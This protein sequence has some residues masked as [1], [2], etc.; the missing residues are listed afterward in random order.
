MSG[1]EFPWGE[2]ADKIARLTIVL[3][4][5]MIAVMLGE[6]LEVLKAQ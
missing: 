5:A 3:L 1:A 4:L 6:I 2:L